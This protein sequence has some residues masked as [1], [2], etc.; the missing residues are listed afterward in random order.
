MCLVIAAA[1][2]DSPVGL[3]AW[4]LEKVRTWSDCGGTPDAALSKDE[5]LTN[6][7]IYWFGGRI[8]SS[9]RLYKETLGNKCV[10]GRAACV[11]AG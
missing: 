3:A 8:A 5:V 10:A 7:A 4:I 1:W 2:Q 6:I 9:M 11:A